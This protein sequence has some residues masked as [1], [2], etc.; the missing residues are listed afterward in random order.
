MTAGT[1]TAI[2]VHPIKS[3]HRLELDRAEISTYGLAGDREW[4]VVGPD[5]S[6]ITQRQHR[7]M[8]TIAPELIDGGLRVTAPGQDLIEIARPPVNDRSAFALLGDEVQV[9][10]GGD[11]AARWF[12]KVLGTDC[13]LVAITPATQRRVPLVKQQPVTFVDAGPVLVTNEAS[14][15]DLRGR[16]NEPFGMERFRP[17]LVVDAGEPWVED[18]WR[19]FSIGEARLDYLLA[20]PRCAVPQIDQDTSERHKEPAVALRAHR[21][22]ESA[23]DMPKGLRAALE[24][25]ALFGISCAVA[26]AGSTVSIGD[27]VEV[28][29]TAPPVIPAPAVG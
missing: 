20:W 2:H 27:P 12:T 4:Q 19:S 22:C 14:L 13:R 5:G 23:P 7:Q 6:A 26:P 18:T 10:D 21:W 3:C 11:D 1:L 28:I 24:G 8:A 16:A 17:N 15:V 25:N 29:A 9:G